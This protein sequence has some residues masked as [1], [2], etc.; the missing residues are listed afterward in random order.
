MHVDV[1]VVNHFK[2][3]FL[4]NRVH[5][6][7]SSLLWVDTFFRKCIRHFVVYISLNLQAY[8]HNTN[9]VLMSWYSK[10]KLKKQGSNKTRGTAVMFLH[11]VKG[12]IKVWQDSVLWHTFH[13][14]RTLKGPFID[15]NRG[16]RGPTYIIWNG[17]K[18]GLFG[19]RVM[20]YFLS[21][22]ITRSC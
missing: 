13:L 7:Y 11:S 4:R 19:S 6:T 3:F 15:K 17:I 8:R 12:N 1:K 18:S 16:R 21:I 9:L 14:Y 10:V 20:I 22:S 2:S 5:F